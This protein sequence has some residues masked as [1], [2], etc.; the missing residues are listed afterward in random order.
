MTVRRFATAS[1]LIAALMV[2]AAQ[3]KVT[4]IVIDETK[5][6][7]EAESGGIATEQIAGRAFGELDAAAPAN[8]LI[9]DVMLARD[10]DGKVRYVASFV[11][12]RPKDPA[13]A[14]GLMWHEV[15][16]RGLRRPNVVA[17]RANGDIDLTSAWQ[18]D[19]AGAT[20]VRATAGVDQPHFL[21]LPIA[22][23]VDGSVVTGEVFARIVNRS[24]TGSQ[25]LIVQSNPVPYKPASLDTR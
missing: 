13:R 20:A 10:P 18:G 2:P 6:L 3:A 9:N 12:T 4:R 25:P 16:N 19:N 5:P 14:S 21:K 11:I 22:R 8:A 15:P 24:G 17:E 1:T 7:V 23:N